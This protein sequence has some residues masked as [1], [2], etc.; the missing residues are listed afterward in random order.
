[1][2]NR[3]K[4]IL[5][6]LLAL[7][8]MFSLFPMQAFAAGN[9]AGVNGHGLG[10]KPVKPRPAPEYP[11]QT[12]VSDEVDGLTVT[13]EAPKGALPAGVE[14]NVTKI[15]NLDGVQAAVDALEDVS[16]TALV[17]ADITFV[18]GGKEIQPK[19]DVTV[20]MASEA[21]PA[22]G[23]LTVVHLDA[24]ADELG[25][26]VEA[27]PVA[28]TSELKAVTFKADS[29]SVYA[30]IGEVIIDDVAGSIDF[31]S[32]N[33]VVTV[34][35]TEEA[36][37]PAGT[38]LTVSEI[39]Y[40]SDEYWELKDQALAKLNENAVFGSELGIN[41]PRGIADAIFVDVSLE[42]NGQPFEPV[43][44]LDV[45]I[46][47]KEGA[48]YCPAGEEAVVVHFGA[49]GTELIEDV[50]C[51][52]APYALPD[53]MHDGALLNS[54]DYE[55]T[56]FSVVGLLTTDVYI[57]FAAAQPGNPDLLNGANF[58]AGLL[59]AEG[60]PTINAGKTV[61]DTNGDGIYELALNIKATS[62]QSSSTSVQKSN[63]VLVIDV[64]G[65]MGN[66]DSYIYYDTYTYNAATY[67]QFR[68][69]SSSSSQNTELFYG[70]YR[71]GGYGSTVH[72]GWY[73]GGQTYQG[74][75]Y[76]ATAYSGT[77]YAYETRLHATQ[78]AAC[79]VVDAL[80][81]YNVNDDNIT[82]IFEI[83]VVKFANR[84][85]NTQQGYNG[86]QMVIRD[87]TSATAI[88]N[89]INGLTAGGGTNWEAAMELALTEANYY[90]NTDTSQ[91]HDPEE[92]TSVIFLTDGF[93]TFYGNDEG[94]TYNDPWWGQ[95]SQAGQE[96][97]DNIALCY[98]NAR[99]D[100]RAIKTAGYTLYNI[101]AF[102][103]DNDYHNNHNGYQY[104]CGLT[105]YTYGSGNNDNF[106]TT[107]TEV[108]QY[109][110]NAKS[111]D[112]LV[113]AF[114]TIIN[115]ITNNVGFAGVNF[116][117]GVS[118]GAT[119]TSVA[120]NG[121]A[122]PELMRYIVK[123][124]TGKLAYE[125]RFTTDNKAIFTIYNADGTKTTLTDETIETVTT[126]V[127]NTSIQSK[128]ASVTDDS[129]EVYD[130]APATIDPDTGMVKW[131][132]AAL[133]I[134]KSGYTYT[135]E[136]DVWP[137]QLTYDI[138]AD[139]NN[140]I[141]PNIDAALAAY[142]VPEADRDQIKNAIVQEEDGSYAIYTNYEQ[143]IEYYPATEVTDDQG[144]H[145]EYGTKVESDLDQPD[146]VPLQGSSLPMAKVWESNLAISELNELLW[147]GGVVG[148]TSL[149]YQITLYV[150]KADNEEA[151]MTKVE[152]GDVSKA[153]I[154]ET[155]GWDANADNESG[156]KGAYVWE[157]DAAVAPGMMLNLE[158][159]AALGYDTTD[160]TKIR[161]FTT[162][163][164]TVKDYYVVE[165]GHYYYVTESGS[166]LHFELDSPLYHPMI[167][168]GTLY[169]VFFGPNGTVTKMDPM[170]SVTAT[171]FLKGGLNI[172]KI[173][174]DF[175][176]NPIE[177]VEDE[178]AFIVK[179]W[180]EDEEGNISPVY[181]Y[182]DQFGAKDNNGNLDPDL[183]IS[184][185]IGYREFGAITNE[186]TGARVT[187]G[188]DVVIFSNSTNAA[189]RLDKNKRGDHEPVYATLTNDNKTQIILRMPANGEIRIVN[190]PRDTK[191]TVEEIID[192]SDDAVYEYV[193][194][195][196]YLKYSTDN[197]E[198]EGGEG[199][200][201][202]T[203]EV[204]ELLSENTNNL[205]R[206]TITGNK[207]NVEKFTNKTDSYF[208]VYHSSDNSIE[209]ISF[210]DNRVKGSY[211]TE[212]G[213]YTYAFNIAAEAK[214][215]TLYG[216][217]YRNYAGKSEGF[218]VTALT[219]DENF[220]ADDAETAKPY[221]NEN[222]GTV[223]WTRSE[224]Y[225]ESGL[226]MTPESDT[227]YYL[228][229]VDASKYLRPYLHYTY[230]IGTGGICTAWLISDQDDMNYE[231][232]G[233]VIINENHEAADIVKSLTVSTTNGTTTIK[234]TPK[235]VF[236]ANN[237]GYLTYLKVIDRNP[238]TGEDSVGLLAKDQE[239][240][241]YWITPD[242]LLVTG[243][244]AR[245]YT[246]LSYIDQIGYTDRDDAYSVTAYT[247]A[248]ADGD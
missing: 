57:N 121:T 72:T 84:T 230:K 223:L 26:D 106:S 98:T 6:L 213:T 172:S 62:N 52:L 129:G 87:S 83:T 157:K 123:D 226:E 247:D 228:K 145:W 37:I 245:V 24:A 224:A 233:F 22:D 215:G 196:S 32:E 238:L 158:A 170:F 209:K 173:V 242:S 202:G 214:D 5:S 81:A 144:T 174:T 199:E 96:T 14:M 235:R 183:A 153:Y 181:T 165:S 136:F 13:V 38:V 103:N 86:T 74:N 220:W 65:S 46:A 28:A 3:S 205:G 140:G 109:C 104:L 40:G 133:G 91:M 210:T 107:T 108:G 59:R 60:D 156:G 4:K 154:T 191:Y 166:D 1:M 124:A 7:V 188:R 55:Q 78:R 194:T 73:S 198:E 43:V 82:D 105:N 36:Q 218:D 177:G 89:A 135:L 134:L 159:A 167:V 118:L 2:K 176:G 112:A 240:L 114:N 217:Y 208:Y 171:N 151:L 146:P 163:S 64:S 29:F 234:L 175:E 216:G 15:E 237:K 19:K 241:Q 150:W 90:K 201:G 80:L 200:P 169:N 182:D 147:E 94:Y 116:T 20:T 203:Q 66:S 138:A 206:G 231:E 18:S 192:T 204:L 127:G 30:V 8:M 17:A 236:G 88:K 56:G 79:A 160:T 193:K 77:V 39:P 21:L 125:V 244:M 54:F 132:L 102:G 131:N 63:V 67:D 58:A 128:I 50:D 212:N 246:N 45:K 222:V 27:E 42:Y 120:V 143:S 195:Q 142:N 99:A 126:P 179:L 161:H 75:V 33:Y 35:Y 155:L 248:P 101:F 48:L 187:L 139:L 184:G 141:Y 211:N 178:F 219:F 16:G 243:T 10:G 100:A 47:L 232:S 11:A 71:T 49:D 130:M 189:T 44:P 149:E 168:D 119:S 85:A 152:E 95:Q 197:E 23:E 92:T 93:P 34:T 53:G 117:D 185:S 225:E 207:A 164:G 12:L 122:K 25:E 41:E 110:F 148:G 190:L 76:Y 97:D 221:S 113:A 227:V 51:G 9:G 111:T 115:H 70:Q 239:V 31:E 162:D 61:N 229:E 137:N 68:Y 186:A 180:K 69:F